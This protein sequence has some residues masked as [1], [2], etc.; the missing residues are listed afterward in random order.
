[1]TLDDEPG[2]GAGFDVLAGLIDA[3]PVGALLADV[4]G[5]IRL[6]N[7]ELADTLGYD[8]TELVGRPVE[9]L[10]PETLRAAHAGW[11]TGFLQQPQR[12]P[13]GQGRALHARMSD[14]SKLPVE[15]G[16][17]PLVLGSERFVLAT[18][19]DLTANRQAEL[20]FRQV[21]DGAPYGVVVVDGSGCIVLANPQADAL[22]GYATHELLGRP[23]ES[24]LPDRYRS[25]HAGLR[26]QYGRDRQMRRM[27]AGRDLTGLHRDGSE[28]PVE[29]GLSPITLHGETC[30]LA[31][32]TDITERKKMELDLRKTNANLEEFTYVASHDLRSPLRGISDLLS[33]V[34]EDLGEAPAPAVVKNLDRITLRVQR[35]EQLI[36]N[37]LSYARAG[38]AATDFRELELDPLLDRVC[39]LVQLPPGFELRR[40]LVETRLFSPPTPLETVLRNLIANAIK[41]HDREHGLVRIGCTAEG[42]YCHLTVTDDGPG[43]PKPAQERIFKLFQT[44]TAAERGG[45]GIGLAVARRLAET[46]GGR[47]ELTSDPELRQTTFH[48]WW[49]RFQRRD[50]HDDKNESAARR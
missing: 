49:P 32:I 4:R 24:L 3:V 8:A 27:G 41:H 23:I 26:E 11:R 46:H 6:V 47:L 17:S 13:M 45:S 15:V 20:L 34:R 10:L 5:T 35:M 9:D 38:R 19:T 25:A 42:S 2:L 28:F 14:G 1:M 40:E 30:M 29:V 33:W 31:A 43:I 21:V 22:F 36:D 12:R 7:R 18:L 39:E 16:L 50:L 44:L 37:L 48:V